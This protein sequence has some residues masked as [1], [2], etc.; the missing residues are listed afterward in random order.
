MEAVL[1]NCDQNG[2]HVMALD[3]AIYPG[4]YP[5]REMRLVDKVDFWVEGKKRGRAGPD[6][7]LS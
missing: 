2:I 6:D 4:F 3:D 7:V 1:W 5:M